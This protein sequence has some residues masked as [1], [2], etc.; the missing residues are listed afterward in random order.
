MQIR[1]SALLFFSLFFDHHQPQDCD[2]LLSWHQ[3][4]SQP[5]CFSSRCFRLLSISSKGEGKSGGKAKAKA[6]L[7]KQL[8]LPSIPAPR[9]TSPS[10]TKAYLLIVQNVSI[11]VTKARVA[12]S[13]RVLRV[14]S[15]RPAIV[16][17]DEPHPLGDD[18]GVVQGSDISRKPEMLIIMGTSLKAHGLKKLVKEFAKSVHSHRTPSPSTSTARTKT[19]SWAAEVV[20]VN[21]TAP[22]LEWAVI[23]DYHVVGATDD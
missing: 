13:A 11:A 1:S 12:R 17:Y 18:I 2:Y 22:G 16:L 23:I 9:S 20:F 10:L 15:L 4:L 6:S 8:A 21:K 19:K 14:G 7:L 3:T 5:P